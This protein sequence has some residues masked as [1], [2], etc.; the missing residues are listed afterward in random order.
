MKKYK[1]PKFENKS[2]YVPITVQNRSWL[3]GYVSG[4]RMLQY[5]IGRSLEDAGI[6]LNANGIELCL[7]SSRF[8]DI[9]EDDRRESDCTKNE[10]QKYYQ[11][12]INKKIDMMNDF[13]PDNDS[14]LDN[15]L[16]VECTCGMGFYSFR[17]PKDVPEK[18]LLCDQCGRT[19]IHYNGHSDEY[20]DYDGNSKTRIAL[21]TEQLDEIFGQEYENEE[22]YEEDEDGEDE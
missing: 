6:E 16:N 15:F 7:D 22:E 5:L 11:D 4:I 21:L 12:M 3:I 9:R 18:S 13:H 14:K 19:I 8:N 2:Q 20:Y 1:P 10:I 17:L